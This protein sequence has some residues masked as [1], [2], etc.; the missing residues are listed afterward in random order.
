[1]HELPVIGQILK[2]V[3][4]HAER[5]HVQKIIAINLDVSQLSDLEEKWMQQ[6][7]D[8]MSK[9]TI[10]EG[11]QLKVERKPIRF[12]CNKC[13]GEFEVDI[14]QV[15]QIRCPVC[16]SEDYMRAPGSDYY[17]KNMEAI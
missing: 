8:Y 5:N 7:F 12:R 16:G 2:V 3:L 13:S 1:M 14:K 4:Q 10:A 15:E 17:I 9:G 6:Y 11:A